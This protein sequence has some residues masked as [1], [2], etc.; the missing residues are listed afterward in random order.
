V[1]VESYFAEGYSPVGSS[2]VVLVEMDCL[3][4]NW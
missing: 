4:G 2:V 1:G 3:V